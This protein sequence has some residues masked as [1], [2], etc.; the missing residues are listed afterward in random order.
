LKGLGPAPL[1]LFAVAGE[2]EMGTEAPVQIPQP[3][4]GEEVLDDYRS[5]RLT[6]KHHPLALLRGDPAMAAVT[7]AAALKDHIEGR[8]TVAGLVLVRQRPGTASGVIF[9]TLEDETGV[10]N[11]IIW[12][13]IFERYRRQ[14]LASSL[15][16]VEGRL[17]REGL[18]VHVIADRID[19]LSQLLRDLGSRDEPIKTEAGRGDQVRHGGGGKP[20]AG[21]LTPTRYIGNRDEAFPSRDFR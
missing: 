8:V 2:E 21:R 20:D 14:V 15:M 10:A 6:L 4:Q 7:P 19:D 17:Q 9:A 11:L 1:P 12:P 3:T 16:R 18:V 5:M 13:K